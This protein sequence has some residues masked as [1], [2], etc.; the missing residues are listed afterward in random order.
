MMSLGLGV[1]CTDLAVEVALQA[2]GCRCDGLS[3]GVGW[4][5]TNVWEDREEGRGE[6]TE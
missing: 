2:D 1:F 4:G 5:L 3:E 6:L